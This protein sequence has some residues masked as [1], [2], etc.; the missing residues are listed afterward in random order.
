LRVAILGC[1]RMGK[2]HAATCQQHGAEVRI[3]CDPDAV[4]AR[5]LVASC[6]S[7]RIVEQS[8]AIDWSDVDA[9]LVCTPPFARGP[10]E[11]AAASA[12][13]ALFMEKPIGLSYVEGRTIHEAVRRSGVITSV[14][15]MNRYRPSVQRAKQLSDE[16]GLLGLVCY[17]VAGIYRVGW[18]GRRELSGGQINEQCT[19]FLDLTRFFCGEIVEVSAMSQGAL[20]GW[21]ENVDA[22]TAVTCRAQN[23]ALATLY[24]NC[25][26]EAKQIGLHL[27]TTSR[28]V[29]LK[30]WGLEMRDSEVATE[31]FDP[32]AAELTAFLDAV[33]TGDRSLIQSDLDSALRTQLVVDAAVRS[34]ETKHP[35]PVHCAAAA[36]T[37]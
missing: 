13:V 30:G 15:Y 2:Q 33:R 5:R 6:P 23:G 31:A 3:L 28:E 32:F 20:P 26:A 17:W 24:A 21:R 29:E 10:A 8:A 14:G 7:A 4:R 9:A 27:F 22:A 36:P 25:A 19:H 1:G 37:D 12:R 11:R 34:L 35:E 16:Y 18:W